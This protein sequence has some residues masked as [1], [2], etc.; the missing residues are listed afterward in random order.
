MPDF[1]LRSS[2]SFISSNEGDTP[3][4]AMRSW[5]K[6]NKACCF[7]VSMGV[8]TW[9]QAAPYPAFDRHPF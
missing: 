9:R 1:D 8:S 7:F 4:S 6:V 3:V 5:M 2:A